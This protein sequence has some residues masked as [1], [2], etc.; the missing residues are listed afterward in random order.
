MDMERKA[1]KVVRT[2]QKAGYQAVFAGGAVRDIFL[3]NIPHDYDIATSAKP[4][5]VQGL[6]KNT[7]AVGKAFGVI[8]VKLKGETFEVA[9]FRKDGNYSDGRRPDSVEFSSMEEDAKRRDFTINAM[10]FD[11]IKKKVFDFEQGQL[12]LDNKEINFVGKPIERIKE[13]NLRL[14]RAIRFAIK[15]DFTIGTETWEAIKKNAHL[16][17]NVAPE[18]IREEFIKMLQLGSPRKMVNLL[19]NSNLINHILPEMVDLKDSPQRED[20]HPEG[21]VLTHTILVMEKLIGEKIEV[22]IAGMLHDVGKPKALVIEDDGT[23]THKGHEVISTEIAEKIMLRLKFSNDEIDLV[24][25]L[26]GDHMRHHVAKK[27]KKSTMKR[28]LSLPH[29]EDLIILNKADTLSASN[30]LSDIDFILSK[31]NEWEP[32]IIKP[33]AIVSGHDLIKL[34]LKPGPIFKIVLLEVETEQLEGNI[35]NRKQALKFLKERIIK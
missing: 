6:F 1:K 29:F 22:Q 18:R 21:D 28:F 3:G 4:D 14:L 17:N 7:N 25:N 35:V 27:W 32:E 2:L 23:P 16:V 19:F 9:T 10:F 24:K 8:L 5:E 13:D 34:G 11:P 30:D 26:V 20:F 15:L 12:D 33:K 31:V